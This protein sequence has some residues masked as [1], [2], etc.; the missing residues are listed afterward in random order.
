MWTLL[1][2]FVFGADDP[3]V[4]PVYRDIHSGLYATE[5]DCMRDL[6]HD[7]WLIDPDRPANLPVP[8][9]WEVATAFCIPAPELIS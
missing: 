4:I 6:E 1:V 8:A 7:G 3:N 5:S 2:L 9:G